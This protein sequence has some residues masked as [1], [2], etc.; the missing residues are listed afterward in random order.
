MIDIRVLSFSF[1]LD[2][3][4]YKGPNPAFV[5][6]VIIAENESTKIIKVK[7]RQTKIANGF[8]F[9]FLLCWV[10]VPNQPGNRALFLKGLATSPQRLTIV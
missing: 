9:I 3:F 2:E 10:A 6:K 8:L 1:N 7:T 4:R 5:D